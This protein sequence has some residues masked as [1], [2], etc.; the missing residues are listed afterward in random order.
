[1]E[2]KIGKTVLDE[3]DY[4]IIGYEN[5]VK[6]GKATVIIQG[7]GNYGETKKVKFT[8]KQKVFSWWWR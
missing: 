6:K 1:M 4:E 8:I 7:K 2:V 3:Q 5:N